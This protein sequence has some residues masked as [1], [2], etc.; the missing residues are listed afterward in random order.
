MTGE[1]SEFLIHTGVRLVAKLV[2][3]KKKRKEKKVGPLGK[4]NTLFRV[5]SGRDKTQ[6]RMCRVSL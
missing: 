4:T 5:S 3:L 1:L 6:K 2:S